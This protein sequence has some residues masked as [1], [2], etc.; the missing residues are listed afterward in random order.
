MQKPISKKLISL[1][2]IIIIFSGLFLVNIGEVKA[3]P[4][5]LEEAAKW[6]IQG[7]A[8]VALHIAQA[9]TAFAGNIF[10]GIVDFGFK[11]MDMVKMGWTIT[12][13]IVNMFF[14]LGLVVIAFATIL[15]IETYGIKTLLPKLI[16]I[17][18]L[19]NFSYLVCGLII[20]ATQIAATYFVNQI[21]TEDI[22]IAVLSRLKVIDAIR[23]VE[24][25]RVAITDYDP[26]MVVILTTAFSAIVVFLAGF[27]M[28]VGAILL[29][30]R[31]G[32]L[33]A[34]IILAPFAW[35]FSI[36]PGKLKS[37]SGQWWDK[38]LMYA[39]F[40]IACILHN[41]DVMHLLSGE[42]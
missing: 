29:F 36:F 20:D 15:R 6:L 22:A 14:I 33:W 3:A 21:E 27:V 41:R 23:G 30:I 25:M 12:R 39:F 2:L 31:V 11:D 18:L 37:Y 40:A 19:I 16:I 10:K 5:V 7:M 1:S 26:D 28:L 35:F 4:G 13:D 24:G 34:L 9:F 42:C 17:A 38:F 8:Q 32:A